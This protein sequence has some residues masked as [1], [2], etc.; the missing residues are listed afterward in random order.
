MNINKTRRLKGGSGTCPSRPKKGLGEKESEPQSLVRHKDIAE[1]DLDGESVD[2]S[3]KSKKKS[4]A[5][6]T[7]KGIVYAFSLKVRM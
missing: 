6:R 7:F 3:D 5:V 2:K 1:Q 4:W